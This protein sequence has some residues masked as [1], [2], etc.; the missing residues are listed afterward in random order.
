MKQIFCCWAFL[1]CLISSSANAGFFGFFSNNPNSALLDAIEES[2]LLE[3]SEIIQGNKSELVSPIDF[4]KAL[5][6]SAKQQ[7]IDIVKLIA[8]NGANMNSIDNKGNTALHYAVTENN[9]ELSRFLLKMGARPS[10]LNASQQSALDIAMANQNI[11]IVRLIDP[12]KIAVLTEQTAFPVVVAA[13]SSGLSGTTIAA[14]GGG[15]AAVGGGAAALGGGGGGGGSSGEEGGSTPPDDSD[16]SAPPPPSSPPST[17]APPSAPTPPSSPTSSEPA[18]YETTEYNRMGGALAQIKAS[19]AY[20]RGYTGKGITIAVIDTGSD[21]DHIDLSPNLSTSNDFNFVNDSATPEDDNGHGTHVAGIAAA[22]RNGFGIHGVAYDSKILSLKVL[23]AIGNGSFADVEDAINYAASSGTRVINLSLSAPSDVHVSLLPS[24]RNSLINTTSQNILIAAATGNDGL[25][26]PNAPAAFAS[27]SS[28]NNSSKQGILL[29]VGAVDSNNNLALF[30]NGC[31][32]ISNYCLVAPGVS[33][34]STYPGNFLA[35]SSGTSMATPIVSGSAAI[36]MEMHPSLSA[37]DVGQILLTTA[38]DLGASGVDDIFGHGL[39]NLDAATKPVGSSSIP[40]EKGSFALS[41]SSLNLGAAFGDALKSS[42]AYLGIADSYNRDFYIDLASASNINRSNFNA[43]RAY[44]K[45]ARDMLIETH[46]LA[47]GSEFSYNYTPTADNEYDTSAASAYSEATPENPLDD[48][49]TFRAAF[50]QLYKNNKFGAYYNIPADQAFGIGA[51]IDSSAG[52]INESSAM[53][54]YMA[55][56]DNG[57]SFT[58]STKISKLVDL[59]FATFNGVDEVTDENVRGF[60]SELTID[61]KKGLK[62]SLQFGLLNE[63]NTF[64][65]SSTSG[66]FATDEE[67][68]TWFSNIGASYQYSSNV[69]LFGSMSGGISNPKAAEASILQDYSSLYSS[70]FTMGAKWDNFSSERDSLRFAI[71]QPLRIESGSADLTTISSQNIDGSFEFAKNSLNLTPTGREI[72][73]E[74]DYKIELTRG[75]NSS[76]NIGALYRHEP[77]HVEGSDPEAI[78]MM[79]LMMGFSI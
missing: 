72:D 19:S 3:V 69:E 61:N 4:N 53:N 49:E 25:A 55:F 66:A 23:N 38:T 57:S 28:V 6:E 2:D 30:S 70:S 9:I 7:N 51:F 73:L 37:E 77:D 20:A 1:I 15:V 74:L 34:I 67:L 27:D 48:S 32:G 35:T 12:T 26:S 54:P 68:S 79:K 10:L 41:G 17:P 63:E 47:E 18:F 16:D 65:G 43:D 50:T 75:K 56:S 29:A 21:L 76:L 64:L 44:S 5:I 11:E 62:T 78:I 59:R 8:K 33:I 14:I 31:Q 36:L 39:V 42:G 40:S 71:S 24:I 46:K 22:P 13:A 52:Y 45:F 60:A 58:S